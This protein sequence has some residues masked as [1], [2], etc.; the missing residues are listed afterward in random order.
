VYNLIKNI[1]GDTLI[2][3][4]V[5]ISILCIYAVTVIALTN[6]LLYQQKISND[7]V[8]MNKIMQDSAED[9]LNKKYVNIL[10]GTSTDKIEGFDRIV[11]V[12][13]NGSFNLKEIN[14]KL[15]STKGEMNL[16]V[17]KG[18]DIN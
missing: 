7:F 12:T 17:E 18:L 9:M 5:S 15:F 1:K 8:K 10:I 3:S 6:N 13:E 2:E 11:T 16:T 4:I 14:I